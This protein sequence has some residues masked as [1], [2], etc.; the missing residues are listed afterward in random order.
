MSLYFMEGMEKKEIVEGKHRVF[1]S[2]KQRIE[3]MY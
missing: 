1:K 3:N 2:T